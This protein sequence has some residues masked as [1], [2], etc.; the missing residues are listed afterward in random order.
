MKS[1]VVLMCK[2]WS[3]VVFTFLLAFVASHSSFAQGGYNWRDR[4]D[5]IVEEI[6]SLS[7][8]SQVT[9]HSTSYALNDDPIRETWHYTLREGKV[10]IFQVRYYVNANEVNEVFYMDKGQLI[11]MEKFETEILSDFDDAIRQGEIFYFLSDRLMQ[12]ISLG[13]N[14]QATTNFDR[15]QLS[16]KLFEERYAELR[17]NLA[18]R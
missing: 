4:V 9:F 8:L 1:A 13:I 16:L 10:A 14:T 18:M 6:D 3:T 2:G 7:M 5:R 11:C 15:Q 17:R 12:Y